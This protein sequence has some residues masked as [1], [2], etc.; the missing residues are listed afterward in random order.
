MVGAHSAA[1][2]VTS[3]LAYQADL[4]APVMFNRGA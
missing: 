1:R 2:D 4:F 3:V